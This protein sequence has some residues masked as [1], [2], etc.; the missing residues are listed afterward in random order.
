MRKNES[1]D[2][3]ESQFEMLFPSLASRFSKVEFDMIKE[4][5]DANEFGVALETTAEIFIEKHYAVTAEILEQM[6]RL[7]A[8]MEMSPEFLPQMQDD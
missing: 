7:A 6:R 8:H 2:Y 5:V 3:V 1:H 4:F